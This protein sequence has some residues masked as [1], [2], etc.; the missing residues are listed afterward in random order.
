MTGPFPLILT[1]HVLHLSFVPLDG[2]RPFLFSDK[3][4]LP[5][6]QVLCWVELSSFGFL[7]K[8]TPRQ[9]ASVNSAGKPCREEKTGEGEAREKEGSTPFQDKPEALP[10]TTPR[11]ELQGSVQDPPPPESPP[12]GAG[13]LVHQLPPAMGRNNSPFLGTVVSL[14]FQPP[15]ASGSLPAKSRWCQ[16]LEVR[17]ESMEMVVCLL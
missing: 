11:W 17:P 8:P 2:H 15:R 10:T 1:N 5:L 7:L 6:P 4:R 12:R 14:S 9:D 3:K 13:L 16:Q